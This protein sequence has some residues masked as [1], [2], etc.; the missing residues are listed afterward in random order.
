[1]AQVCVLHHLVT[2]GFSINIQILDGVGMLTQLNAMLMRNVMNILED[3]RHRF[4]LIS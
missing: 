2:H 1:M 4:H 3:C